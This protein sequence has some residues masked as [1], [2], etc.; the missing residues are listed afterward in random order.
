MT[1]KKALIKLE[2][3]EVHNAR[4]EYAANKKWGYGCDLYNNVMSEKMFR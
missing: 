4:A 1:A 2:K 3:A